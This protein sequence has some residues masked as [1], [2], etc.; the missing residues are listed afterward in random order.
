[1]RDASISACKRQP[2]MKRKSVSLTGANVAITL[3]FHDLHTR[4]FGLTKSVASS[5]AEAAMVC[6]DRHHVPVVELEIEDKKAKTVAT[7]DWPTVSD[8]VKAAWNNEIDATEQ[9]ASAVALASVEATRGMVAV[10]RAETLSGSD[11]YIDAPGA[12]VVDLETTYRLEISGIDAGDLKQVGYRLNKK[13]KQAKA[14]SS[15]L[16]AIA[17]VVGFKILKVATD[18]VS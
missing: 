7:V 1:M 13:I 14:G 4:H 3:K 15:N 16:P 12:V 17:C 9:G 10:S 6:F 5:Y 18:D 8:Q 2:K 11:Y